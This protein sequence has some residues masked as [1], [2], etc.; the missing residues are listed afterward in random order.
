MPP[1]DAIKSPTI[2]FNGWGNLIKEIGF[3]I[4]AFFAIFYLVVIA[5][6]RSDKT[7][8]KNTETVAES[9]RIL[10]QVVQQNTQFQTGVEVDHLDFK[11]DLQ[12]IK[13]DCIKVD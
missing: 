6:D 12:K 8:I 10:T 9:T 2:R 13:D 3:P 5:M 1:K 4:V 7:L 11:N